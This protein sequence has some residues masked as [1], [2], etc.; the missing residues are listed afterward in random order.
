M[1]ITTLIENVVYNEGLCAEHGLSFWIE[2]FNKKILFDVGQTDKFFCNSTQLGIDIREADYIVISHGHYDHTGG[3]EFFLKTNK[4]AEIIIKK[5]AFIDKYSSSTGKTRYIGIRNKQILLENEYRIKYVNDIM[6]IGDINFIGK[7][8]ITNDFENDEKKLLIKNEE[9]NYIKDSFNDE[10]VMIIDR[11]EGVDIITGCSHSGII[12]SINTVKKVFP[13]KEVKSVIGGFHLRG[14][15]ENRIEKTIKYFKNEKINFIGI[16]HCS[17]IDFY[18]R[19][20]NEVNTD[21][22]YLYTG[23]TKKIC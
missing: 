3:L 2:A 12:N 16:N 22:E 5:E 4:K 18:N 13:N 14:G 11:N 1:E 20:K 9:G 23:K 8:D 10:L 15:S 7:I 17:G 19:M 21:I 6:K